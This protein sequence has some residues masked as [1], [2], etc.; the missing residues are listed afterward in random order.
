MTALRDFFKQIASDQ[1]KTETPES[2]L[3][4]T[5]EIPPSVPTVETAAPSETPVPV[6]APIP[7]VEPTAIPIQK[8]E[9]QNTMGWAGWLAKLLQLIPL[10]VQGVETIHTEAKNGT[11]KKQMA[12]DALGFATAGAQAF[13]PD[14]QQAAVAAASDLASTVIDKT[15]A[16][17]NAVKGKK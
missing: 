3:L 2:S 14:S 5:A 15:V 8:S 1:A 13:A 6:A 11:V 10:V 12:M 16:V 7:V 9:V 17:M 4:E